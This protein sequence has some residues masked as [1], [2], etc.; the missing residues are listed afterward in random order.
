ME[1]TLRKVYKVTFLHY[2]DK[3][4]NI[5]SSCEG[6][7]MIKLPDDTTTLVFEEDIDL[8]QEFGGGIK[9]LE[10]VGELLCMEAIPEGFGG[11]SL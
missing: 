3:T 5:I 2:E 4:K 6:A 7:I 11:L 10:Y 8:I 9:T 1:Y